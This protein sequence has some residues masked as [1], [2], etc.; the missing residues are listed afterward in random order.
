[1]CSVAER[2]IIGLL[3]AADIE[4]AGVIDGE[5][6]GFDAR[7]G[8]GAIAKGLLLG[9]PAAAIKISLTFG[10]LDL[11]RPRLCD[12]RLL[13]HGTLLRSRRVPARLS[14]IRW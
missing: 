14:S 11:I 6:Q 2:L 4:R 5:T 1:M 12:D 9:A 3:A 13:G 7:T 10:Q 8:V